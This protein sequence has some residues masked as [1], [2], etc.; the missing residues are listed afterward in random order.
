[1]DTENEI[2]EQNCIKKHG[3]KKRKSQTKKM[4]RVDSW[5]KHEHEQS[6]TKTKNENENENEKIKWKKK[7]KWKM[8]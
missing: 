8:K 1:M 6:R 3:N 2:E 4:K 5:M 7:T